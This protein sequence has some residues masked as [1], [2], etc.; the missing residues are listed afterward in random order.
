MDTGARC[1]S[2]A[3][4][5]RLIGPV[6][7]LVGVKRL[8]RYPSADGLEK[9]CAQLI[10]LD[11]GSN[12]TTSAIAQGCR[13]LFPYRTLSGRLVGLVLPAQAAVGAE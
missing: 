2:H 6:P 7:V 3:W 8:S 10:H 4:N 12:S 11:R 5:W 9:K 13:P 1:R